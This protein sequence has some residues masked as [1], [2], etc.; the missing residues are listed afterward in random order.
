M[1]T[2]VSSL[3]L[4]HLRGLRAGLDRVENGMAELRLRTSSVES[5][6]AA[7]HADMALVHARL[8]RLPERLERIERRLDLVPG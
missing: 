6:V 3:I 8:D 4:E 1:D 2:D 5:Q 7:V